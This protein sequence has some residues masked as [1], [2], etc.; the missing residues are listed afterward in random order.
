MIYFI[1]SY[2]GGG[3]F[4]PVLVRQKSIF[5]PLASKME[6]YF[7]WILMHEDAVLIHCGSLWR[8]WWYIVFHFWD[9]DPSN[10]RY[11]RKWISILLARYF[12]GVL[13][14]NIVLETTLI[15]LD[16]SNTIQLGSRRF[17][18]LKW[19]QKRSHKITIFT[20]SCHEFWVMI[21]FIHKLWMITMHKIIIYWNIKRQNNNRKRF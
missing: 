17:K 7:T 10:F 4:D 20:I 8:W 9:L 1:V 6:V 13:N 11:D 16:F 14:W 2:R 21:L 12:I 18:Q 19:I 15:Q 3:P 5:D